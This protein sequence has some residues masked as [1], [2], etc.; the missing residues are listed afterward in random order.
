MMHDKLVPL[1]EAAAICRD[2]ACLGLTVATL[3]NTPMAF[4]RELL[5]RN[6]KNLKVVTLSGG[7]LNIDLLLGGGAVAEYETCACSLGKYGQ[8]PNFQRAL[9][10]GSIHLKDST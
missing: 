9:R 8:A 1:E 3:D 2:G 7:G 4:L 5:R 6:T 10:K